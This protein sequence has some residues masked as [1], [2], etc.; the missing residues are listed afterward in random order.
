MDYD[1]FIE[2]Y[3]RRLI[4]QLNSS[5]PKRRERLV[6]LIAMEDPSY[7][8]LDGSRSSISK[9]ELME[10]YHKLPKSIAQELRLP[11]VLLR[12][13]E[14]GEGVY[15]LEGGKV[16][17]DAFTALLGLDFSLSKAPD[18]KYFT[19]KPLVF[20]FLRMYASLAV[21]GF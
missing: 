11:F 17:A 5:L 3:Y 14:L 20:K 21:I 10:V 8:A 4:H 9:E 2:S 7:E 13:Y 12:N 18:G 19:Y 6:D 1:R 15:S 16:E